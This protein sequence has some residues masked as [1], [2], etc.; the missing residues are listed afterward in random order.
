MAKGKNCNLSYTANDIAHSF[1]LWVMKIEQGHTLSGQSAQSKNMK[2]FYPRAYSPGDISVSGRCEDETEWQK[3]AYFIRAHQRNLINTPFDERFARINTSNPGYKRLM[4]LSIPDEAMSV[5][6]WID[7]F[8]IAKKGFTNVAPE[9]SF[10]F[11]VVF[12]YTATDIGISSRVQ[13]YYDLDLGVQ[14]K[15]GSAKKTSPAQTQAAEEAI[16]DNPADIPSIIQT[17]PS[18]PNT[19]FT[20]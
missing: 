9:F 6:G 20:P 11:F 16:R 8:S 13:K 4:R 3:L 5:R 1:P 14:A 12:D 7:T 10:D 15:K 17:R 2:H 19:Q 18:L